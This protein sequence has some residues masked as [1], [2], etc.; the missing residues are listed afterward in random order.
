MDKVKKV[1]V[2]SRFRSRDSTSNSD[3]KFELN[4][5]LDLPD[6]TF[7]YVDD[8]SIPHTWRTIESHDNKLYIIF[9]TEYLA[10]GGSEMYAA[11]NH[12]AYVLEIPEGNYTGPALANAIQEQL[13]FAVSLDFE[14][15]YNASRGAITIKSNYDGMLEKSFIIPN[16]FGILTWSSQGADYPWVNKQGIVIAVD[17]GSPNSINGVL[18]NSHNDEFIPVN[19]QTDFY[20]TYE[21]GFLDLLSIH[22]IYMHC[23]NLGHFNSIG[24]RGE[25]S[26][27]K[28]IP[29]SSS[30]GYLILDSVVSPHD[31]MDVSRQTVKTIHITLKNVSGNVINLHGANCSFSLVFVTTE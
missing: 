27:I 21:S 16:D 14:V 1:Y 22:N 19:T 23:E 9:K 13:S 30:F 7:C 6:N 25:N 15:V 8:I 26:I 4:E 29:V 28:K 31:K 17:T 12:T 10:G 24:V 5:S 18:R 11:Y 20:S 2:D 3:F